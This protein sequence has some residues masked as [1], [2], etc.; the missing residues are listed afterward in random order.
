MAQVVQ[1]RCPHC[2]NVLRIPAEWLSKSMRCK[3]CQNTFQAK[4]NA[5]V[6]SANVAAGVPLAQPATAIAAPPKTPAKTPVGFDAGE[7]PTPTITKARKSGGGGLLL[8]VVMFFFLFMIG[9]AAVGFVGYKVWSEWGELTQPKAI[10]KADGAKA[11]GNRP[12][13]KDKNNPGD[14][15][16]AK[17]GGNPSKD[18]QLTPPPGD[19]AAK[20]DKKKTTSGTDAKKDTK[21]DKKGALPPSTKDPFPRRALL[22]SVNNYLMFSTVQYGSGRESGKGATVYPGSSTGVLRDLLSR[23]LMLIPP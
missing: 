7:P 9:I 2:Q 12:A 23:P 19:S 4:E 10:A 11:D 22:I 3:H 21:K 15:A 17:D 1:A 5:T 20:K 14:G 18:G 8:M 6:K 13:A 16:A